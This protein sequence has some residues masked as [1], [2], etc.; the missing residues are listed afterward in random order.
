MLLLR[1]DK[2]PTAKALCEWI[3]HLFEDTGT[4][5]ESEERRLHA[6]F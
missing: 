4:K 3:K 1:F 2:N 6:I 5:S